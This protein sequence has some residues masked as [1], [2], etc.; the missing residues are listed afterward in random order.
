MQIELTVEDGGT[1]EKWFNNQNIVCIYDARLPSYE[2][3]Y[4]A[5]TLQILKEFNF[6]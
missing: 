5:I 4:R 2:K 1:E 3:I 6:W